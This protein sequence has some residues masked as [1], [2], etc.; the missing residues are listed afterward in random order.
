MVVSVREVV[1]LPSSALMPLEKGVFQKQ[2]RSPHVG[3][4][5]LTTQRW[6][7]LLGLPYKRY[8]HRATQSS[9]KASSFQPKH[10]HFHRYSL[11][12]WDRKTWSWSSLHGVLLQA[13]QTGWDFSCF[14]Q[15]TNTFQP[16]D[17]CHF[18]N[19]WPIAW[20]WQGNSHLSPPTSTQ[21]NMPSSV[22]RHSDSGISTQ[23]QRGIW[24]KGYSQCRTAPG[25][26]GPL[27]KKTRRRLLSGHFG[28]PRAVSASVCSAMQLASTD[29]LVE[30]I[31]NV[32]LLSAPQQV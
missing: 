3:C 9:C 16:A 6:K 15:T 19:V 32:K 12:V 20:F 4:P 11:P 13:W 17:S 10:L 21:P 18:F 14:S 1:L 27:F 26:H 30:S 25:A 29:K 5:C 8:M 23:E 2:C 24:H 22:P 28:L 7:Q 31:R